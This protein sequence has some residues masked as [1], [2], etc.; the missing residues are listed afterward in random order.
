MIITPTISI[1]RQLRVADIAP[2]SFALPMDCQNAVITV[3]IPV[4]T[5]LTAKI[6]RETAARSIADA[7]L[8]P[9]NH[10]SAFENTA[11]STARIPPPTTATK[12]AF[13]KTVKI[14]SVS[15]SPAKKE[16]TVESEYKHDNRTEYICRSHTEAV[17]DKFSDIRNIDF[18][19]KQGNTPSVLSCSNSNK[20]FFASIPP[21]YPV[22]DRLL[23]ITR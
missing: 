7:S 9:K 19:K 2:A 1:K 22:S 16:V 23:P 14:P 21:P 3:L 5:M 11:Q 8:I 20:N 18:Y 12:R 6:R 4:N 17:T 13:F 10:T 15:D